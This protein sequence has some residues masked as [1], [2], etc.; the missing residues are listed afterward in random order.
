MASWC[1]VMAVLEPVK[2]VITNFKAVS[3]TEVDVLN[4]PHL[5]QKGSHK[6]T[7]DPFD[8]YMERSDVR[9][10]CLQQCATVHSLSLIVYIASI[11]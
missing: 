5:P 4:I 9:E 8:L 7:F 2:V 10:V 6:V 11:I 3:A 1:R